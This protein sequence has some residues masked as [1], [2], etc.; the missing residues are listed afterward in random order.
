VGVLLRPLKAE[1]R[2]TPEIFAPNRASI[3]FLNAVI[4][5]YGPDQPGF[6]AEAERLGA[7]RRRVSS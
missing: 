3:A 1:E 2:I 7:S 4:A 6:R 5:Q